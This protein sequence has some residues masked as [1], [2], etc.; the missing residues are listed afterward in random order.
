[1]FNP[2]TP[3]A[4]KTSAFPLV[5]RM[6]QIIKTAENIIVEAKRR[7]EIAVLFYPPYYATELERPVDSASQLIFNFSAIRRGAYFDG[8]LKALQV[9]NVDYDMLDLNKSASDWSKYKQ[10]WV[11]STDEMN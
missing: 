3:E 8:L 7:A 5:Q 10:I 1:W 6:S 4:E 9:L 11:F 2:L